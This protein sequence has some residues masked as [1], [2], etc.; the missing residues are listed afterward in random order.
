MLSVDDN[1]SPRG[2]QT[3]QTS[4]ARDR[5]QSGGTKA[6]KIA[7]GRSGRGTKLQA[8]AA[9]L[10]LWI[11]GPS[12]TLALLVR[13]HWGRVAHN[14]GIALEEAARRGRGW[15]AG[16]RAWS[17]VAAALQLFFFR[18]AAVRRRDWRKA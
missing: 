3:L 18:P 9:T 11:V 10:E 4:R 7:C 15:L 5:N 13:P 2:A 8:K 14:E 12:T 6:G 16:W 1:C 17:V